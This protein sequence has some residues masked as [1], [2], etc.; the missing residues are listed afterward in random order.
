MFCFCP[1]C[2]KINQPVAGLHR[3][4][5]KLK[6]PEQQAPKAKKARKRQAAAIIA[7]AEGQQGFNT[8]K[9]KLKEWIEQSQDNDLI[10]K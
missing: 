8:L 3:W 7:D 1:A 2:Q 10:K 6:A 9:D 5:R 4:K